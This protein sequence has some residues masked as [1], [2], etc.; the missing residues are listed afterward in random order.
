MTEKDKLWCVHIPGPGDIYAMP[1]K[2]DAESFAARHNAAIDEYW[3]DVQRTKNKE[4]LELYPTINKIRA[5]VIEWPWHPKEHAEQLAR[6]AM[7]TLEQT[8]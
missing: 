3:I 5:R 8:K 2:A 6:I 7:E 4:Q 1:S